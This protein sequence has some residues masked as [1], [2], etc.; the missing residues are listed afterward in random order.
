M[1][2]SSSTDAVTDTVQ[3]QASLMLLDTEIQ[4]YKCVCV[5]LHTYLYIA[6]LKYQVD[7]NKVSEHAAPT[8]A[9]H[10]IVSYCSQRFS[11]ANHTC[12]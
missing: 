1:S 8:A 2:N 10:A 5:Y 3:R 11:P 9:F 6:H 12:V 4:I 7:T